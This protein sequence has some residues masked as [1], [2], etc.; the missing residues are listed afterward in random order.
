MNKQFIFIPLVVLAACA[1][2]SAPVSGTLGELIQERD[3]LKAVQL[4]VK[5]QLKTV[6]EQ[7]LVLDSSV[8]YDAVT[9]LELTPGEFSHSFDVLGTVQADKSLDLYP[10]GSGKVESV[11]VKK[12]Q[13]VTKGQLLVSLNTDVLESSKKELLKGLELAQT[14][15]EK[16]RTLWMDEQIGSEIQ[17][18][19]AKNNFESLEQKLVTL[20]EQI[21]LSQVRAPFSGTIDEVYSNVGDLAAPQMPSVRLVNTTGSYIKA[22][23]PESYASQIK[24]G[25]TAGILFDLNSDPIVSEVIQVGQFIKDANRSFTINVS[26][27][28][29][30]GVKPNQIVHVSLT[31]YASDTALVV[32]SS[33]VQ[34]D[35]QGLSFLYTLNKKGSYEEVVKNLVQTGAT[36]NGLTEIKRGLEAGDRVIEKGSRSVREGQRVVVVQP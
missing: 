31:D 36:S 32:P 11:H 25:T 15:Y 8:S 29:E 1:P 21:E 5:A 4:S 16:Q 19:Q 23:V 2:E 10:T 9:A 3:S 17:F 13:V 28:G 35:A 12:G 20:N 33:L 7:I 27:P 18:L 6:E 14:V 34:Q 26:I 30:V 22:D 24:P